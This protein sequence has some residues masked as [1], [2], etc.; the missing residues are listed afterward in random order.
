[1][2]IKNDVGSVTHG[3]K[4]GEILTTACS[5]SPFELH[6]PFLSSSLT[7]RRALDPAA[8][9]LAC[10]VCCST[11]VNFIVLAGVVHCSSS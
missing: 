5:P 8:I 7:G 2:A 4:V 9:L 3:H 1:M 11:L 6:F 10:M